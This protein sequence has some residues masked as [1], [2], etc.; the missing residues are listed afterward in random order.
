MKVILEV[1]FLFFRNIYVKFTELKTLIQKSYT[2]IKVLPTTSQIKLI[3]NR[4]FSKQ[5]VDK[6]PKTFIVHIIALKDIKI[7]KISIDPSQAAQIVA[8]Q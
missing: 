2:A 4:E 6:N 3:D 7:T 1:F 8:W 5:V